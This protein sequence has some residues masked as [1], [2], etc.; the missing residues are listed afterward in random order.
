[1]KYDYS[2]IFSLQGKRAIVTGALGF[3]GR[4]ICNALG[5]FGADVAVIDLDKNG[6]QSFADELK[7]AY[8]VKSIGI[9]CNISAATEVEQMMGILENCWGD[10]HILF[11]NAAT[12]TKDLSKFFSKVEE[13][14]LNTWREVMEV[15]LDGMFLVAQKVGAHMKER[16]VKGS[17]IQTSS[18]YGIL[19]PDQRIYKDSNFLGQEINTPAVYSASKAGVIGLSRYLATYW[20][21]YGIRVNTITPGG[22]QTGQNDE[23]VSNYSNRVPLGRMG[24]ISEMAGAVIFLAS[25][26]SSYVTGQNVVIDGGLSV[27]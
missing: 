9:A 27:W 11:N 2:K 25:E 13:Y 19:G 15:N 16:G 4:E 1:M 10:I 8:G 7:E 20:G 17:I 12:K 23:F 21:K 5:Q 18:I 24:S 22:L 26:A 14:T 6:V 3:I